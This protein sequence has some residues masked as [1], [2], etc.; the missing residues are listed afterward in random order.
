[1]GG[2][3]AAQA[4]QGLFQTKNYCLALL[5]NLHVLVQSDNTTAVSYVKKMGG[6][7]HGLR[8]QFALDLWNFAIEHNIWLPITHIVLVLTIIR[9]TMPV[10]FLIIPELNGLYNSL[11]L[12]I[13]CKESGPV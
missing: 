4:A 5:I 9:L 2:V 10:V 7:E 1:M 3:L 12:M 6:T 11:C 8:N 13:Y